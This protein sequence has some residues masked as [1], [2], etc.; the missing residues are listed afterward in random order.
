MTRLELKQKEL[1]ELLKRIFE[2][3]TLDLPKVD[4][5]ESEIAELEKQAETES[6]HER[7]KPYIS[8]EEAVVSKWIREDKEKQAEE[9]ETER[10]KMPL[11]KDLVGIAVLFNNG[12]FQERKL[13]DMIGMCQFVLDRLYEN[14]D[15]MKPSNKEQK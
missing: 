10:F 5:L 6:I 8:D 4:K 7:I 9:Q 13:A 3:D 2:T 12:K 11:G 14:N 1:I 15:V